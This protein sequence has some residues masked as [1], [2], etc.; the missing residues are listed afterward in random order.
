MVF[1]LLAFYHGPATY[2]VMLVVGILLV[3]GALLLRPGR[4]LRRGDRSGA[5]VR[6]GV[7][8]PQCGHR[9]PPRARFCARCG[10]KLNDDAE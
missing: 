8:C 3:A 10:H 4:R 6:P 7:P 2:V 1:G 9:L 5:A